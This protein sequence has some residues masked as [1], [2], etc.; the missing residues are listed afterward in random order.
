MLVTASDKIDLR[1]CLRVELVDFVQK[2]FN[3]PMYRAKQIWD[4]GHKHRVR[5]IDDMNNLPKSI[6]NDL[7]DKATLTTLDLKE[8]Q[9]SSDG[10]YKIRFETS[11]HTSIESVLI[12]SRGKYTQ[13]ISSQVGCAMGCKFCATAKMGLIRHL[14]AGEIVDQVY[15]ARTFLDNRKDTRR[16]GNLVY[17]GMGE[18]LHNYDHVVRSIKILIDPEGINF[19]HRKITLSTSGLVPA[20]RKLGKE[21]FQVNLAV[22]LNGASDDIRSKTMPINK[23]YNLAMLIDV[24]SEYPLDARRRITFEWIMLAGITD[25]IKQADKLLKLLTKLPCKL[26]LIPWNPHPNSDYKR[27][28]NEQIE[29]FQRYILDHG[30]QATIRVPRGEDID[31]ACGQLALAESKK[32]DNIVPLSIKEESS[33]NLY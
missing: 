22:S 12:P 5:S 9:C 19:S 25:S 29:T 6:R 4:W 18:P 17:M 10:T 13:C 33:S 30:M 20:I 28:S 3:V 16:I 26:N 7:N 8:V 2:E 23:T 1:S 15:R 14:T 24:L 32:Q 21:S 11:D 27:S 31:A